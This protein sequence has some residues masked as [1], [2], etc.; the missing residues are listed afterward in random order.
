MLLCIAAVRELMGAG[1]LFGV[2]VLGEWWTRWIIMVMPPAGFFMLAAF[3]LSFAYGIKRWIKAAL[4]FTPFAFL[5]VDVAS[6]WLTKFD[7]VF[8]WL[9]IIGGFAY[10]LASTIMILT[11]LWQI[12]IT[13]WRQGPVDCNAWNGDRDRL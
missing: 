8:A 13:P 11:S 7:P 1:S 12:W 10:T 4:I 5:I 9:T 6:W 3:S 2:P